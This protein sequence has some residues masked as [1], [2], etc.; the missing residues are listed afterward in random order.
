MNTYSYFTTQCV[1]L[2]RAFGRMTS[3]SILYSSFPFVSGERFFFRLACSTRGDGE[4]RCIIEYVERISHKRF[5]R[6]RQFFFMWYSR[7]A[8]KFTRKESNTHRTN[9]KHTY[10]V[11]IIV[12]DGLLLRLNLFFSLSYYI[13]K[14]KNVRYQLE[15]L[16]K[17][18]LLLLFFQSNP[19]C[20]L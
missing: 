8:M 7:V 11:I 2:A 9:R 19:T 17:L 15:T 6:K 16:L 14:D 18:I 13:A 5:S 4:S 12:Y 1:Y 20:Y 10:A 3:R